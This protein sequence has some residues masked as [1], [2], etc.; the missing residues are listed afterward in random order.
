MA[1]I[2]K[3]LIFLIGFV[4]FSFNFS[5]GGDF[6]YLRTNEG[7]NNGE[8]NSIAQDKSGKMWFATWDGLTSYDGFN[9]QLFKPE[10]GNPLS[11]SDKKVTKILVDSQDNLWINTLSGVS[12]YKKEDQT[13]HSL[14]MEGLTPKNY[15]VIG[16]LE[17]KG[18]ILIHTSVGIF[19][20]YSPNGT[21][22]DFQAKKLKLFNET[23]EYRDFIHHSTSFKDK[24]VF[25]SNANLNA[26]TRILLTELVINEQDTLLK[27]KN[28]LLYQKQIN[29]V[30]YVKNESKIYMGT[31][32]GISSILIPSI[33]IVDHVFFKGVNIQNLLCV[34]ENKIY[35][36]S[37]KSALLYADLKS[38]QT[39]QYL[40]N[41]LIAGSLLDSKI[42]C[43]FEDFSGNLWVGHQG[44]GLSIMSLNKKAFHSFKRDPLVSN[45][46]SE[47]MVMCF[48]GTEKEIIIGLRQGGLNVTPKR[49][50]IDGTPEFSQVGYLQ[51][52]NAE[53]PFN[54]V[55]SIARES[56]S[57]FWVASTGGLARLQKT[58]NGWEYG[59]QN[60]KP[61]YEK[62]SRIVMIDKD[63]NFWL[64]TD[65]GLIFIPALKKNPDRKFFLYPYDAANQEGISNGRILSMLIDSKNRFWVGTFEGLNLMKIPYDQ[66]DLAGN[67]MPELRFKQF[68]ATK[69]EKGFLNANEI[70]CILENTDG[71]IWI[72]TEGGGINILTPDSARFSSLTTDNGLPGNNV[73]GILSDKAGIKWISTNKGILSY[74]QTNQTKPFSYYKHADGLQGEIFMVNAYYQSSDGEMY[75]G[76][77]NGFTRFYPNQIKLNPIPP[78]ISL[79][80][81]RIQNRQVNVGDNIS[82]GNILTKALNETDY[83]ELPYQ[84]NSFSIGFGVHHYQYPE[85]N[86]IRYK[87]EEYRDQWITIPASNQYIHFSKLPYGDY[88]L[89]ITA[90]TADNIESETEKILEIR[91]LPPWYHTWYFRSLMVIL[92]MATIGYMV[93]WQARKQKLAFQREIHDISAKNNEAKMQFL[94]NIAH[95]LRTPLSLVIA[96]IEDMQQNYTNIDSAWENHLKLISRNSNYLMSLINQIID[97][98]KLGTAK[99]QV[100]L[101]KTDIVSLVRGVV[102]N[103]KGLEKR[104]KINLKLKLPTNAILLEI[105]HEKIEGVLYNLLSNAFKH[106]EENHNIEVSLKVISE[107]LNGEGERK[108]IRIT[109]FNEGID[110]SDKDKVRIFERFYKVNE[111]V[112]GAGIGLSF[113]KSLIE[114]HNGTITVESVDG[115]GVSFHV[116]LPVDNSKNIESVAHP[117]KADTLS[118]RNSHETEHVDL[119]ENNDKEMTIVIVEDN[120]DLRTFLKNKLSKSYI[121]HEAAN[122]KKG[123]E[124]ITRILPDIVISDVIMPKM[125][126][127]EL[128]EKIKE[129]IKT[130]HIPIILLTANNASEHVISG[131]Q[132]G[133]DAYI[134]KPFEM[135]VILAQI[136]R[137]IKN[138]ELIRNKYVT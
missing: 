112:E 111:N 33:H 49:P 34:G 13:F 72:G 101:Q 134:T 138:R 51:S 71:K 77:D 59:S 10:L 99:F 3:C 75:F 5:L 114:M 96:P 25:V 73:Y 100:S 2:Y 19:L 62:F 8:I 12:Y 23:K 107:N 105:D 89:H 121:C 81:L 125:D 117:K 131:Y 128:C 78:R 69:P 18:K 95:E 7:L 74:D 63:R 37:T 86:K 15:P 65:E 130:C 97:F 44:M 103:F 127:Y 122:G 70:N 39:G 16:I 80:N 21:N 61:L 66:L 116:D 132:K 84:D 11:L 91:I 133:A 93:Y 88:T 29:S 40:P 17:S 104:Q 85:G 31:N 82:K 30:V 54:Q 26:P 120:I 32:D 47:N 67:E 1:A 24:L 43:L 36:Y 115:I 76:G 57:V 60:E 113:S 83:I 109:V 87:L 9:F 108:Q 90:V 129:N 46:L 135:N 110:I 48:N 35:C 79:T 28:E 52:K 106:T 58:R 22:T 38:Q 41:P 64:G 53:S 14:K 20:V 102:A 42:K 118:Y 124:L 56:D 119:P 137:L 45:S 98:R 50:R 136:S 94:T 27:I 68:V 55:W 4:F 6:R 123:Y 92:V 126:G